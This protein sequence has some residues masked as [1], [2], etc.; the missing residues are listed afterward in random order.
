[1]SHLRLRLLTA[2]AALV[3]LA[4]AGNAFA[5]GNLVIS[6]V[7][8]GGGNSGASYTHDFVELFNGTGAAIS[9][10]GMSIQYA[11]AT[12]TGAFGANSGQLTELAGVLPAGKYLLV[13]EAS[14]AAV[15]A[16]LPSAD[17]TDATPIAMAAGAG[18]VALATGATSLGCN[19]GSVVCSPA[20]LARIVD[21]VGY[22]NANFF[23]GAGAAPTL[24]SSS[25]AA[26]AG[27]GCTDTNNNNA[28]FTAITPPAPRNTQSP[29][30]SCVVGDTA[31]SVASTSPT[32]GATSVSPSSDIS[33]TFSE[34]G[35]VAGGWFT[36]DCA[37]SGAHSATVSGGA[38]TFT[39]D[40]TTNFRANES[41]TVTVLGGGVTDQ[42]ATDPPDA[43]AANHTFTFQTADVFLCGEPATPIHDVQG[44]GL[45]SP[46]SGIVT[47]EGVVGGDY[48][49]T[50][51]EFGGFYL[52]EEAADADANDATSE[53]IF[54]F[55]NNLGV[56]VNTGD[57]VRV[58]GMIQESSGLTRLT[59]VN[60]VQVCSSGAA[61]PVSSVSL[62]VASIT[63]LERFEGMRVHF[64]QTLT[65]TEVFSLGRFGEVSLSG[66]GRLYIPTA[67]T[68]PGAAAVA[69]LAENN[70]SRIVLDDGV[71]FQN[72]DPTVHP[73][74]GLSASNTLRVG[75]ST[76]GLNGVMDF[77]FG[78]YR[79]QPVE[80]VVFAPTNPR[81][82]AP[83][84]VGGNLKIASFNVLNYFNGDGT[85]GGYPTSRGATTA[86]EFDR[87]R[88]K[89]IAAL[90]AI[91]ADVVGLMEIENDATG[92]SAIEDLVAGLNNATAPGTYA[93]IDTGVI[94]GDAI[95]VALVY[96][97]AAV[98]PVGLHRII[99]SAVDPRFDDTRSR[100]SLAQTFRQN[101]SGGKLT[102][103]VS[104]LKSKGSPCA[105]DPDIRDGQGNCN[106]TR[107][108]A[109]RALVDWIATDPTG[110]GDPDFLLI[111]DMNAYTFEDPITAFTNGG[112]T[113]LLRQFGGLTPY[114]Y[115]FNGE[116]GYLD[117]AL[118]TSSLASQVTGATDWHINPDEPTVLDYNVEFKTANQVNTFYAPTPYRA[119]D[120][121]PVVLGIHMNSPPVA[122][123]GGPYTVAEGGAVTLTASA[124]DVDGGALSYA[125]D[126]DN[127]GAFDDATGAS[128]TFSAA[129]LDG[130]V[131]K[132]VRVQVTDSG[133]LSSTDE[134]TVTVT[135]VAPTATFNAP[136]SALAGSAF[137]LSFTNPD[138]AAA[139]DEPGLTYAFDCGA[140]YGAFTAATTATCPTLAV[141]TRSVGGKVRDDDGGVTEY[142]DTV[143]VGVTFASLCELTKAYV[144]KDGVAHAL[145]AKL[146]AAAR[147][148]ARGKD[149]D[150][151]NYINQV[152][153]QSGKALTAEHAATLIALA[154]N[155]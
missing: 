45:A 40:P 103:I 76:S 18:K 146:E 130:P 86:F 136:E 2:V 149:I 122:D 42:D 43:M 13:Q 154:R 20:A 49:L 48:Q 23:E 38:T 84:S 107:T 72:I 137:T 1:M 152:E 30:H 15:G 8:G 119:S 110:S 142:R 114:S 57:I 143:S 82:A 153:A 134:A 61:V 92:N 47:V 123:A 44:S 125:W 32:G 75:Y 67:V 34:P 109:A 70:R 68:T 77:R 6:Q 111:G 116:S 85:G 88:V 46:M 155:L 55:D 59:T 89:I 36:I 60:A 104:H 69:Q 91:D 3:A 132:T 16:P 65:A 118:A 10:D 50:P 22:G 117:H 108:N 39:L 148:D 51:R 11:S 7:Y 21:L 93:F 81:T 83:E 97:P 138:D 94:G 95:K 56:A 74:G 73:A 87:Q 144:T 90:K 100:P 102:V 31:P 150:L 129:T 37:S 78:L 113:N 128:T 71:N 9:L 140:G 124:T 131:S 4:G 147:A 66:V 25:S 133:G 106:Q 19:G 17:V 24:T 64:D 79:I 145:C 26:R 54:V 115:V 5:A 141:G 135:N 80:P 98:S 62:P 96:K 33:I 121:D 139:A 58:R 112:F 41:C 28:D 35:N 52:Q 101:A 120:H 151:K 14:Q 53:G 127:D 12:G 29:S 105:G 63:D 126:L 27:N 99:T